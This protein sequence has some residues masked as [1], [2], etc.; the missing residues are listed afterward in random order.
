MPPGSKSPESLPNWANIRHL[1]YAATLTNFAYLR[2]QEL[3]NALL[4]EA[5]PDPF[6]GM[7]LITH[8]FTLLAYEAFAYVLKLKPNPLKVPSALLAVQP[9]F[10]SSREG[11]FSETHIQ[12]PE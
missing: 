10:T 9:L 8:R 12:D 4:G 5:F 7:R 2:P 11:V 1:D 3:H 6:E